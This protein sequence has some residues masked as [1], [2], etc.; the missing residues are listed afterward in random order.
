MAGEGR[1]VMN[2]GVQ[3]LL[4]SVN[5]IV[6]DKAGTRTN[7]KVASLRTQEYSKQVMHET[8]RRLHRLGYRIEDIGSL[9][10]KHIEAV[11]KSWHE[12]GL[13][14]KTMQNQYSRLKIFVNDWMGKRGL[15]KTGGIAEYL[16][17]VDPKTLKV[18]T[19]T[20]ETKSW[21]GQGVDIKEW[22]NKAQRI[23]TRFEGM[24]LMGLAFGLRKKEMLEIKPWKA[25]K[26]ESLDIDG[27]VAKNGRFRSIKMDGEYGHFQREVLNHVKG[28][29]K[30]SE[31][32]GW[33]GRTKK[34][35][36]NRYY[37]Y[38]ASIGATKYESGVTGHGLRAEFAENQAMLLGLLPPAL[39]GD[40]RQM[41]KIE[42]EEITLRVSNQMGH[43]RVAVLGAYYG[44]FRKV[45]AKETGIGERVGTFV[46][47]EESVCHVHAN[48]M[49]VP[50]PDG[51]YRKLS[52][53][54][55]RQLDI[56]LVIEGEEL[57]SRKLEIEA[58]DQDQA[59]TDAS[60]QRLRR[61]LEKVGL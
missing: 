1:S 24:L 31:T 4:D 16:P 52:E 54:E 27:S 29:V 18:Q 42:R 61:L 19:Y 43:G 5:V 12:E 60:K 45:P 20:V 44:T 30:R 22:L 40:K 2:S 46:L 8:C 36:E 47:N 11:V 37:K 49:I 23:D 35:N 57:Q 6:R 28:L 59:H 33:P 58:F 39:G 50:G 13:S 25:D 26:G 9:K 56:T 10:E 51:T 41:S 53:E 14:N 34:Q 38:M 48:P 15:V 7:G 17:A 21:S 32:L 55:K 3:G